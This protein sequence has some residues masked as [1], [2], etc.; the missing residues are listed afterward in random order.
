MYL[1]DI[2]TTY[3]RNSQDRPLPGVRAKRYFPHH[4]TTRQPPPRY[5][6]YVSRAQIK[7]ATSA[8]LRPTACKNHLLDPWCHSASLIP[9]RH[10]SRVSHLSQLLR[11][12]S[13]SR[14][15]NARSTNVQRA[16]R[17]QPPPRVFPTGTGALFCAVWGFRPYIQMPGSLPSKTRN[18]GKPQH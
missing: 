18:S 5:T 6:S 2:F 11:L 10:V 16:N 7:Y 13:G 4:P 3:D 12:T 15:H 9:F 8:A 1:P 17:Q 14:F